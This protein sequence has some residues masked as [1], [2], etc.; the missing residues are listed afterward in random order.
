ML[1]LLNGLQQ[2]WSARRQFG[3]GKSQGFFVRMCLCVN[4]WHDEVEGESGG[5]G[6][7]KRM[8]LERQKTCFVSLY[9]KNKTQRYKLCLSRD[10][11]CLLFIFVLCFASTYVT[12]IYI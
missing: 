4:V 2:L 12:G 5:G 7:M 8:I 11:H 10:V 6:G 1:L 9:N 3:R